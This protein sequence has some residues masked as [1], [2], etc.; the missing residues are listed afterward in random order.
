MTCTEFA[1]PCSRLA[2]HLRRQTSMAD[3]H[4]LEQPHNLVEPS[5]VGILV[6]AN[7]QLQLSGWTIRMELDLLTNELL[8]LLKIKR[9]IG[10]NN[11]A[12]VGEIDD[13]ARFLGRLFLLAGL[14]R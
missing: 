4:T 1:R 7:Q 13:Q 9:L 10:D 11:L 8:Q 14:H 12:H 6:G 3:I 5:R 2:R